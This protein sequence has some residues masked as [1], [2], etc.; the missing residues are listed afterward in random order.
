MRILS[1]TNTFS[2]VHS[3]RVFVDEIALRNF[4]VIEEQ[5]KLADFGQSILLPLTADV[6]TVCD[7]DLTA[8]I[9]IL[10]LGWIIY[11]IAVW[12][13]HKYYF[14]D[15]ENLHWPKPQEL[16]EV[17]NISC[18]HIIKKCLF[19]DYV[20]MDVLNE[21]AHSLLGRLGARA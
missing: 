4:L 17:N 15:P 6:D 12:V 5:L 21:E 13:V 8:Q 20:S 14:F 2:Y 3:R 9:E 16:P 7:N 19:R 11:S 18:G 1:L 10:H